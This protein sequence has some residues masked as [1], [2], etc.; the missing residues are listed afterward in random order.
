MKT[1][2]FE[3]ELTTLQLNDVVCVKVLKDSVEIVF[4][5]PVK[6]EKGDFK[7]VP[8]Y[9]HKVG[10]HYIDAIHWCPRQYRTQFLDLICTVGGFDLKELEHFSR[11][12]TGT[13][14]SVRY[15]QFIP[16]QT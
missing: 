2:Y 11:G 8:M 9:L 10:E 7:L 13:L 15:Y 12:D 3:N 16:Q 5:R 1:L 4:K 14:N 6:S